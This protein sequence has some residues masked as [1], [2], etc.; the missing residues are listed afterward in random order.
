MPRETHLVAKRRN[1]NLRRRIETLFI[2]AH[3]IW[4]GYGVDVA[5]VFKDNSQYYT[6]RSKENPTWPPSMAEIVRNT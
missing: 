5:M 2:K 6:Y 4:D 1:D 3:E